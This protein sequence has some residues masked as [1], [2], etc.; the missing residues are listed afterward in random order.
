MDQHCPAKDSKTIRDLIKPTSTTKSKN[1]ETA[2]KSPPTTRT[3]PPQTPSPATQPP[4]T[5][6]PK[7]KP[8]KI[9]R[10]KRQPKKNLRENRDKSTDLIGAIGHTFN[11]ITKQFVKPLEMFGITNINN[12]K[13]P[14]L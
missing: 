1:T 14:F 5:Q 10:P 11:E 9:K 8:R 12:I 13:K 7:R 4:C 2:E 6:P 3:G